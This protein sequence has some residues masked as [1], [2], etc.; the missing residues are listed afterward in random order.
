MRSWTLESRAHDVPQIIQQRLQTAGVPIG[1]L[2]PSLLTDRLGRAL[3]AAGGYQVRGGEAL[4][5]KQ[6][7]VI[8]TA[9]D[10]LCGQVIIQSIVEVCFISCEKHYRPV[11]KNLWWKKYSDYVKSDNT[12]R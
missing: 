3:W 11:L 6:H 12:T 4:K 2:F 8:V 5:V 7:K 9:M 10:I 1:C